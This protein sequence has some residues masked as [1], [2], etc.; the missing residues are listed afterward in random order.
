MLILLSHFRVN[1]NTIKRVLRVI[2]STNGDANPETNEVNLKRSLTNV[3]FHLFDDNFFTTPAEVSIEFP[4][5]PSRQNWNCEEKEEADL[6][7]L[8][9]EKHL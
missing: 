9:Y 1:Q 4:L 8:Q 3:S 2:K 5:S 6:M 7:P